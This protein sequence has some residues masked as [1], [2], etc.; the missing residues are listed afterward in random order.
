[1]TDLQLVAAEGRS[2]MND[3][4]SAKSSGT[5]AIT[6]AILQLVHGGMV[7]KSRT[8]DVHVRNGEIRED[9]RRAEKSGAGARC[10]MSENL[11]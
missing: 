8:W 2:F 10:P 6:V 1:L 11:V 3:W 5:R 4:F 7:S 9:Q